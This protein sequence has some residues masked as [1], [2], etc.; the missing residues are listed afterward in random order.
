MSRVISPEIYKFK[1]PQGQIFLG[2][3]TSPLLLREGRVEQAL[4]RPGLQ[5]NASPSWVHTPGKPEGP[6][7]DDPGVVTAPWRAGFS[8]AQTR[9]QTAKLNP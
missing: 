9:T 5:P 3:V 1:V 7:A 8:H 6:K 4:L 2:G